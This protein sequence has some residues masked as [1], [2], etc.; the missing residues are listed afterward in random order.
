MRAAFNRHTREGYRAELHAPPLDD[1]LLQE[2]RTTSDE[3]LSTMGE[4][5]MQF[6]LGWFEDDYIR[7]SPVMAVH[8][9]GGLITAFANITSEYQRNEATIDLMRHRRDVE[10]GTMDFL[11]V[12]LF[13]WARQQGYDTF[14]LGLSGLAGV[15]ASPGA[16]PIERTLRYISR[17]ASRFYNFQ[18]LYQ[19]KDKFHPEWSPRYLIYPGAASLPLVGSALVRAHSGD[20]FWRNVVTDWIRQRRQSQGKRK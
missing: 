10:W 3:W 7:N 11:F 15:G 19:F 14:N 12:S 2:L 18:G 20:S 5:E 6:S 1:A 17:H 4:S 13:Q 9:A 16:P 8:T